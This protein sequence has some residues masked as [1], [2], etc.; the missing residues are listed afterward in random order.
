MLPRPSRRVS[1]SL[2]GMRAMRNRPARA[3][4]RRD[5]HGF[6]NLLIRCAV[7]ARIVRVD[8][9]AI[10]ALG[11]EGYAEC[12]QLLILSRD[13]SLSQSSLIE[14]RKGLHRLGRMNLESS[15]LV[16]IFDIV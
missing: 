16:Q 3:Q 9:D 7:P 8:L 6:G 1:D 11:R 15:H 14:G 2:H 13:R 10:G 12:Y 5:E 4:R